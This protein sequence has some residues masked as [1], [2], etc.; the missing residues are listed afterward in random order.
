MFKLAVLGPILSG[1]F[2]LVRQC[3]QCYRRQ[4][5]GSDPPCAGF[6]AGCLGYRPTTL[7]ADPSDYHVRLIAKNA[8]SR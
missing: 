4:P 8:P 7:V 3:T 1:G 2:G 6:G 5:A